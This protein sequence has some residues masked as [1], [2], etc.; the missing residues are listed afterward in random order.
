MP[1]LARLL[2]AALV[3]ALAGCGGQPPGAEPATP[4]P[5]PTPTAPSSAPAS[6]T[7]AAGP[8]DV[9]AAVAVADGRVRDG[10]R[11]IEAA[12]GDRVRLRVTSD[13][14]DE[15]HVHGYDLH[16]PVGPDEPATVTFTADLP[17]VYEV[18]LHDS[19]L[20]VAELVVGG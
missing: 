19:G 5:A 8:A 13:V 1:T 12:V 3:L 2:P 10:T 17:G 9:E 16:A 15:I 18:E 4:P 20:A 7:R 11:R 6:P 14:T